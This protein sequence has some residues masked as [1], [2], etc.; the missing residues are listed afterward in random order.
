M[1]VEFVVLGAAAAALVALA[2]SASV[3]LTLPLARRHLHR[4]DPDARARLVTSL[5]LLPLVASVVSVFVAVSPWMGALVDHCEVHGHHPHLCPSHAVLHDAPVP[6]LLAAWLVMA[7]SVAAFRAARS[8]WG[9]FV[10]SRKL[11]EASTEGG[12][13]TRVLEDDEPYACVAGLLAPEVFISRAL[14]D[15]AS[16]G[17]LRV[18]LAHERAHALRRDPLLRWAAAIGLAFHLP[19]VGRALASMLACAQEAAAD[20]D[21]AVAVGERAPVAHAILELARMRLRVVSGATDWAAFEGADVEARVL[22]LLE[23]RPRAN[24]PRWLVALVALGAGA[25][26]G[27]G[28]RHVHHA[29]ETALG[30]LGA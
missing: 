23:D 6:W 26:L 9:S 14:L 10:A 24:V 30:L 29:L 16:P 27:L 12:C 3:A 22:E 2:S 7:A 19:G 15:R 20:R 21:A 18:V 8:A 11:R 4:L 1:S 5:A 28:G 17:S 13:G 25:A